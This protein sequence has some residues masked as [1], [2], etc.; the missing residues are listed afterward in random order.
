MD[1]L[2]KLRKTRGLHRSSVT[3]YI[4]KINSD[5]EEKIDSLTTKDLQ[6]ALNYLNI[7]STQLK[8]YDKLIQNLIKDDKE[9]ET[10]IESAFEYNEKIIVCLSKL[11]AQLKCLQ[12][13]SERQSISSNVSLLGATGNPNLD[14]INNTQESSAIVPVNEYNFKTIKL[15]KLTIEKYYG[16]PCCWLEFWNQFQ[17]SIDNNKS[18]SKID[19]FSYLKSLLGGAAAIA[20]NGFALSDENYDQALKLLKQRFGREELVINAHMSK[21]LNLVPVTDSN[22]IYG[23]RKLYDTV[24]INLRSLESLKVTSEMYGHLLYPILI[25]LIPEDLVLEFNRKKVDN[26]SLRSKFWKRWNQEYLNSLQSRAKWKLPQLNI[27]P[28]QLVLLKDNSKSPME[29][30]LARIERTY[31]G[32]DGLV[33]VADIRTPKGIF[34]RSINRLCPLPFEEVSIGGLKGNPVNSF[35]FQC[36]DLQSFSVGADKCIRSD[37]IPKLLKGSVT[38]QCEITEVCPKSFFPSLVADFENLSSDLTALYKFPVLND[39]T[40]RIQHFTFPLHKCILFARCRRLSHL[41]GC[42]SFNQIPMF[43][44]N[45]DISPSLFH[46]LVSYLYSGKLEGTHFPLELFLFANTLKLQSLKQLAYEKVQEYRKQSEIAVQ[47]VTITWNLKEIKFCERDALP[48]VQMFQ[49]GC[50]MTHLVVRVGI[51]EHL[52]GEKYIDV[53]FKVF[54]NILHKPVSLLCVMT[55]FSNGKVRDF[56]KHSC[57]IEPDEEWHFPPFVKIS[58]IPK[59][60]EG[61]VA[62]MC[63]ITDV[64][65]SDGCTANDNLHTKT[66]IFTQSLPIVY[67]ERLATD[68]GRLHSSNVISRFMKPD[69]FLKSIDNCC[70]PAHKAILWARWPAIRGDLLK[71]FGKLES[72][73][74]LNLYSEE[75]QMLLRYIYTG[76]LPYINYSIAEK[77]L[78]ANSRIEYPPYMVKKCKYLIYGITS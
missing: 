64:S 42:Q 66:R 49:V 41:F 2:S 54:L 46:Q 73:L 38:L 75:I 76:S 33:R 69:I 7:S 22:N 29:W 20:V 68:L 36:V 65:L 59:G 8:D 9:F 17:N 48:F 40:V 78:Q 5:L 28:G 12:D 27:K 14:A 70:I 21:L 71:S 10:E 3:K 18:L 26:S 60:M 72:F 52:D 55:L 39:L 1:E 44:Q 67:H 30:N 61:Y 15:P 37:S 77:L 13:K 47:T 24:E 62:D 23:L 51:L 56:K 74:P 11:S 53:S 57:S 6:E 31:P 45:N 16:D 4:N 34:R 63:L 58:D 35:G 32:T 25:K 50:C 19:K 43:V